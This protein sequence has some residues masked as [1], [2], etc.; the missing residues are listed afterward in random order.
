[1]ESVKLEGGGGKSVTLRLVLTGR[2]WDEMFEG[3]KDVEYREQSAHWRRLIWDRR[4]RI[5]HA[6]FSRGYTRHSI[7]RA[8]V[9]I[10]I[11]PCE[12][13]GWPSIYY[14]LRL[15]PVLRVEREGWQPFWVASS[16]RDE[17]THR[18]SRCDLRHCGE[19]RVFAH[20]SP[21]S[22]RLGVLLCPL[23]GESRV[24]IPDL[25]KKFWQRFLPMQEGGGV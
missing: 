6:V 17:E 22:D 5:T 23:C 11:G 14:R 2:W 12:Y 3:K 8:V 7:L 20:R 4:A 13:A 15:G 24:F 25:E 21:A 1:M 9:G 10:D 19:D 18:C 16:M